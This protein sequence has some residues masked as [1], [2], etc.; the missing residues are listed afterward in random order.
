[1][2]RNA[3][4]LAGRRGF[5]SIAM[6]LIGAGSGGGQAERV[7]SW[8]QDELGRIEFDGRVVIVRYKPA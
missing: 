3:L 5:R 2:V 6:L 7:L 8:M 1:L 4:A